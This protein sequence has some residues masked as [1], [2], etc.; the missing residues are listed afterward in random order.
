MNK[1]LHIS[2]TQFLN[3]SRVL[4]ETQTLVESGFVNEVFVTAL[5][6]EGLEEH[7]KIDNNRTLWRVPLKSRN[8]SKSLLFQ[9]FKYIEYAIKVGK[10]A[11]KNK[12]TIVTIHG[13][14]L[15]PLGFLI[16]L[17]CGAKLVYDC[18]E[19][20]TEMFGLHGM[21]KRAA[22]WI[23]R[24]FISTVDLV[25]VVSQSINDWYVD[26]YNLENI[27]TVLN[28]PHKVILKRT[29]R[30]Q[31]ELGIPMDKKIVLYQGGLQEGRGIEELLSVFSRW[32]DELHVL[33]FMGYGGLELKVK[34]AAYKFPNI[35]YQPAV[36]PDIVLSYTCS[37]HVGVSYIY[38]DSLNDRY[39]L[40]NK[41]FEYLMAGLPVLVNNAPEMKRLVEERQVGM[42]LEDMTPEV[43]TRA[44]NNLDLMDQ[45]A[46]YVR[47]AETADDYTWEKQAL[48]LVEAHQKWLV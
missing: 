28:C 9:L 48:V 5:W 25:I 39:C 40:P 22:K 29:D 11:K 27:C 17:T 15:L 21:R 43:L 35:Y 7:V 13:L 10:Y 33:V 24:L 45:E 23:E 1:N 47:I 2:L 8:W 42:V 31:T 32:N 37:A 16:K 36:P 6:E 38:N 19:L 20:E 14:G 26:A 46:L 3:E 34:E 18:H 12:I 4:K 44:L 30:L 41:L